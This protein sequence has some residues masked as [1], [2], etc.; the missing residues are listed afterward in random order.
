MKL[1]FDPVSTGPFFS[2]ADVVVVEVTVFSFSLFSISS[3]GEFDVLVE[4]PPPKSELYN[5][6]CYLKC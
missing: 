1:L 2:P 6:F 3:P 4:L 5:S